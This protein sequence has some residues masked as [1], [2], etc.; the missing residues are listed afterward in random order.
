M[1][2]LKEYRQKVI[3]SEKLNVVLNTVNWFCFNYSDKN[4]HKVHISMHI[5]N[6][7]S[8]INCIRHYLKIA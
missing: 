8:A 2:K 6:S 7:R 1:S 4:G 3:D 5:T